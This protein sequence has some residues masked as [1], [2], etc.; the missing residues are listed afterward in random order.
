M[1]TFPIRAEHLPQTWTFPRLTRF[2][3][4][5]SSV[6]DVY[7]EALEQAHEVR[8]RYPFASE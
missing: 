3:A 7:S 4:V 1:T 8:R 5:L 2:F 6:L